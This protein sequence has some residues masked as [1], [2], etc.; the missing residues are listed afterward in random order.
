MSSRVNDVNM[1]NQHTAS[2]DLYFELLPIVLLTLHF[3]TCSLTL[4]C[5]RVRVC[6]CGYL[7]RNTEIAK[8]NAFMWLTLVIVLLHQLVECPQ[9][10][11]LRKRNVLSVC[12]CVTCSQLFATHHAIISTAALCCLKP[13]ERAM[14]IAI[15]TMTVLGIYF[16]ARTTASSSTLRGVPDGIVV[17]M[18]CVVH[19]HSELVACTHFRVMFACTVC[20][21]ECS[22]LL[23]G[24]DGTLKLQCVTVETSTTQMWCL[25]SLL[26]IFS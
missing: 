26:V 18:V 2:H 23:C 6:V 19:V 9:Q 4:V 7:S 12:V 22:S 20:S 8:S 25:R 21:I 14:A 16:V 24:V 17:M 1:E 10:S 15:I 11:L 13:A 5:V 3:I